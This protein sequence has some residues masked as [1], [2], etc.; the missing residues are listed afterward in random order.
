VGR[1]EVLYDECSYFVPSHGCLIKVKVSSLEAGDVAIIDEKIT[2][3]EV[4]VVA[5]DYSLVED[6]T[7]RVA[8]VLFDPLQFVR[9]SISVVPRRSGEHKQIEIMMES[10][11][12]FDRT[13]NG[14][15]QC[16]NLGLFVGL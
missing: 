5:E 6:R 2:I 12:C 11:N 15:H 7:F 3:V 13:R 9:G 16:K 14:I 4:L 10:K 8:K 1:I